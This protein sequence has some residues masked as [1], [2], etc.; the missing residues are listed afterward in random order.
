MSKNFE[1]LDKY[2]EKGMALQTAITLLEW[3]NETLAPKLADEN[4]ANVMATLSD[5]YFQTYTCDEVKQLLDKCFEEK[6][7][8]SFEQ[9]KILVEL[10][11]IYKNLEPIPREEYKEYAKLTAAASK[12]WAKAKGESDFDEFLPV[13]DEII[14]Y[15]KKF[16][17]YRGKEGEASYD[18]LLKEFEESFNMEKLDSFFQQIKEE[19]VPFIKKVVEKNDKIDKSYNQQKYDI[20]KQKEFAFWIAEYLGFDFD[21]GV[22]A[23]SAHPFT[24]NLHNCDIRITDHYHEDNL[25]SGIFSIIHETGHALYEMGIADNIT[26]TLI[27]AGTS[28]AMH[29]SQSRFLENVVGRSKAFWKPI[30]GKLQEVFKEQL[31]NVSLQEFIEGI[32]KAKPGIFRTEADELTYPLHIL[33]RYEIEKMLFA[34]EIETKDLPE[35]WREKYKS[36]LGIVPENDGEGVLQDVHWSNGD[37]GYFPSYALGSAIAAQIYYHMKEIMPFETY[38]EEGNLSPII[39]YLREHVHQYG[40]SKSVEEILQD[41]MNEGFNSE[42][43]IRYLKEKYQEVYQI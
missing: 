42:Y 41:M 28:M 23:E 12:I 18:I 15:Q 30:Y 9:Q 3:D 24:T 6:E 37:F 35:I 10:D 17:S 39:E 22:I 27:G 4:T 32:N 14:S 8:Y 33:I 19:I 25:E 11:K 2:F 26:Q 29:E 38:L 5:E 31:N 16:A 43:Y 34:D 7:M 20:E 13:L 40:K 1:A 21:K 36:Y